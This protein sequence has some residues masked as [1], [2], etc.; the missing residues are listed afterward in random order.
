MDTFQC[1]SINSKGE[2]TT[3]Y[4][5]TPMCISL[6]RRRLMSFSDERAR[7]YGKLVSL[8]HKKIFEA[9]DQAALPL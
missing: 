8:A 9:K 4:L 3:L 6:N 2:K 7:Q 5:F 1:M